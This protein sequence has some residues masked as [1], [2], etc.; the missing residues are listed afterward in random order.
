[1]A[2]SII[3]IKYQDHDYEAAVDD[4]GTVIMIWSV[5]QIMAHGNVT[6]CRRQIWNQA[7]GSA[8]GSL[9]NIVRQIVESIN[10]I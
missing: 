8:T 7:I 4:D 6:P 9:S 3:K 5:Y 1:M 10:R 2:K